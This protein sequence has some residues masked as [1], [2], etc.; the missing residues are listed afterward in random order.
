MCQACVTS[1]TKDTI[2]SDN[3]IFITD[4]RFSIYSHSLT[5]KAQKLEVVQRALHVRKYQS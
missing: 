1:S 4:L 5:F 2:L 3:Y